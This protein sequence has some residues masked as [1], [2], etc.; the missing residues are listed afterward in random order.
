MQVS[1]KLLGRSAPHGAR[2]AEL[3]GPGLR[4]IL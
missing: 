1:A 4:Y 2:P 3:F